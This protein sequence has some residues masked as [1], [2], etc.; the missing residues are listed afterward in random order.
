MPNGELVY[1]RTQAKSWQT[2]ITMYQKSIDNVNLAL[3]ASDILTD[4]AFFAAV[5]ALTMGLANALAGTALATRVGAAVTS[6]IGSAAAGATGAEAATGSLMSIDAALRVVAGIGAGTTARLG[7]V[8]LTKAFASIASRMMV[9]PVVTGAAMCVQ[10]KMRGG[11]IDERFLK[12][13]LFKGMALS[14]VLAWL[15]APGPKTDVQSS[16]IKRIAIELPSWRQASTTLMPSAQA[17]LAGGSPTYKLFDRVFTGQYD[18]NAIKLAMQKDGLSFEKQMEKIVDA[19]SE[20]MRLWS[21]QT[22]NQIMNSTRN[23]AAML[24]YKSQVSTVAAAGHAWREY[25]GNDA[26]LDQRLKTQ[27]TELFVAQSGRD[28]WEGMVVFYEGLEKAASTGR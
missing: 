17:L 22:S 21:L 24:D 13:E 27:Y 18:I 7:T 20:Q 28:F 4:V 1:A 12:E 23:R 9:A 10:Q 19:T 26:P 2:Y 25:F 5:S 3:K 11:S 16:L 6:R 8:E 14:V 15:A